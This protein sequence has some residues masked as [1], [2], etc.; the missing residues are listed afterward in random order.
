VEFVE[1]LDQQFPQ[2]G[3]WATGDDRWL[4]WVINDVYGTNFPR[5][6]A[7]HGKLMAWT[8]WTHAP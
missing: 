8:D 7:S 6:E 1:R 3:W 2:A 4:P 5:E